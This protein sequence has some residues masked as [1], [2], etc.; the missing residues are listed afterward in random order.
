MILLADAL[1]AVRRNVHIYGPDWRVLI[2]VR[3]HTEVPALWDEVHAHMQASSLKV[4]SARYATRVM[5]LEKGAIMRFASG[6]DVM[7]FAGHTYTHIIWLGTPN[8]KVEEYVKPLLRS[9]VVP[10]DV[11]RNDYA[12]W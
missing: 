2:V 4:E 7:S 8:P 10:H 6:D 3:N 11:L 5:Q 12:E 1:K 9:T